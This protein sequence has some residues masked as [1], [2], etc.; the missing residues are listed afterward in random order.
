MSDSLLG[1]VPYV[2]PSWIAPHI[3]AAL[4]PGHRL[5]LGR[6]PTPIHAFRLEGETAF[7]MYI[8]RDDL[9]SFDLSG[10]KV[11]KLEFL[12]SEALDKGHDSVLTIGGIQSNHARSTAVAA[13]QLGLDPFL[14]LR[15]REAGEDPGLVGN[16]LLDRL[17]GAK[18]YQ[19]RV[20]PRS[21]PHTR[22]LSN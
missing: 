5:Q 1:A 9:S 3:P 20:A 17:V 16:L 8:K 10:N 15:S 18:I 14:I 6:F 19:V 12:L 11:R 13:R 22:M 2:P 4:V 21:T 7:N